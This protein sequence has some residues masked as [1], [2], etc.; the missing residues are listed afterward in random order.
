MHLFVDPVALW[1]IASRL[2]GWLLISPGFT[3]INTPQLTRAGIIMWLSFLLLP[4]IGPIQAHLDTVPDLIVAA[5]I[6]F[7][8]GAGYGFMLRLIF[9][10]VQFGGVLL[11]SELGY[12]YAQQVN[13]Y[14][15][16]QSGVFS[17]LFLLLSIL[18]FWIFDYF[19]IVIAALHQ[20]FLLI[21]LGSLDRP[22][23]DVG[24]FVKLGTALFAGGLTFAAP[25]IALMFFVNLSLGLLSRTVHGLQ[26]FGEVF[27][28]K[29]VV[30]LI[31]IFLL[32]PLFFL[33][34]RVELEKIVPLSSQYFKFT[35]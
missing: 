30:G 31:G 20:S 15:A 19:R 16:T 8:I 6:E 22:V 33:L 28:L 27:T 3:E 4:L 26:I 34:M 1:L 14:A 7:C 25:I 10:A 21:P 13:P 9:S 17:R 32:L 23:F 5:F 12:T 11:D 24:L 2:T 18:Y 35:P 29:I